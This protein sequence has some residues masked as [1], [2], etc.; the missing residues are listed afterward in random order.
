MLHLP[1]PPSCVSTFCAVLLY[2]VVARHGYLRGDGD[3]LELLQDPFFCGSWPR[4]LY[5]PP[6]IAFFVAGLSTSSA[7]L[8]AEAPTIKRFNREGNKF[9]DP[10]IVKKRNQPSFCVVVLYHPPF[11][12]AASYI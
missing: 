2:Y 5:L 4:H 8:F 10:L 11:F 9:E 3:D 12:S 6:L 7:P 1:P